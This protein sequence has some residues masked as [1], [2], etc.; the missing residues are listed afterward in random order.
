LSE[1]EHRLLVRDL[2]DTDAPIPEQSM[3]PLLAE[4]ARQAPDD[5][6]VVW[7]TGE[8]TAAD[9]HRAAMTLAAD[10]IAAG[11]RPGTLVRASLP[12]G[13]EL[14]VA[15]LAVLACRAVFVPV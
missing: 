7:S 1:Y 4:S 3:Y 10:L 9:L 6:A 14:I 11:V 2:N 15:G 5:L 8:L 12:R 13:P